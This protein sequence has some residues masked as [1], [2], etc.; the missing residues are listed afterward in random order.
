[1]GA[2]DGY[3][4]AWNALGSE[5][6]GVVHRLCL[7][8]GGGAHRCPDA[9]AITPDAGVVGDR[10]ARDPK[11]DVAA[12]V[13][14]MRWDVATLVAGGGAPPEAAGDNVF[15]DLDLSEAALPVGS[16]IRIGAVEL[17]VTDKPHLGCS[18]FRARFGADAMRWVN[19]PEHRDR[20]LRGV[21]TTVR[22]GGA[23]RVGD[24]AVVVGIV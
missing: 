16:V 1:M 7:R 12:Q 20:R 17:V 9:V 22:A 3:E 5:R 14:L 6:T 23:I 10:W 11:R 4:A 24:R 21:N 8:L 19:A 15:V 13:T 2:T 18:K